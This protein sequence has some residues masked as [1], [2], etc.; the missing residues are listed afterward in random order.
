[1]PSAPSAYDAPNARAVTPYTATADSS[2]RPVKRCASVAPN[3]SEAA[4]IDSAVP[5]AKTTSATAAVV[6][7]GVALTSRMLAPA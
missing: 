6:V 3:A 2:R 1:M 5:S 4:A 7:S